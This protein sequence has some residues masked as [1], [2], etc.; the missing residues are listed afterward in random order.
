MAAEFDP[1]IELN[2]NPILMWVTIFVLAAFGTVFMIIT[3]GDP[4]PADAPAA[5]AAP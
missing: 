3:T 2:P 1:N 5:A 4:R